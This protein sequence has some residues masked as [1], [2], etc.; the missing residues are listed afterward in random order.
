MIFCLACD[1]TPSL[2]VGSW[3]AV[4]VREA[5]DSLRLD[6]GEIRFHFTD[7]GRY[8]YRSTLNYREAGA[9]RLRDGFLYA[10]DTTGNGAGEYI[11][12]VDVLN[13]DSL[14]LRM[15]GEASERIVL[16]LRE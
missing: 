9:Y 6:P 11:V 2:L 15:Q 5:G 13:Q 16:L 14:Q 7:D 12:A 4:D 10:T 3:R 1:R 8:T